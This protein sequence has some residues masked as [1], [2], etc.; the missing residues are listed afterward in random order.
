MARPGATHTWMFGRLCVHAGRGAGA[1]ISSQHLT[2]ETA[3][4]SQSPTAETRARKQARTQRHTQP[5]LQ[6][7]NNRAVLGSR[8]RPTT[9]CNKARLT[10]GPETHERFFP[11]HKA[12]GNSRRS[13]C[14]LPSHPCT[15]PR[16][17]PSLSL[18]LLF[19]CHPSTALRRTT[20]ACTHT[21][22]ARTHRW[23]TAPVGAYYA[24]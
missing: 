24:P 9:L 12:R 6:R 16:P 5:A 3:I 15:N 10:S 8:I 14:L 17:L 11:S 23:K 22:I 20:H 21:D 4:A 13:R 2:T 19:P 1:A 18:A 7:T